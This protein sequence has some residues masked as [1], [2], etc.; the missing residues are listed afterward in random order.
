MKGLQLPHDVSIV[1]VQILV[2]ALA[3]SGVMKTPEIVHLPLKAQKGSKRGRDADN[4]EP[5]YGKWER[6]VPRQ[7]SL[8]CN[9]NRSVRTHGVRQRP[10][11]WID[12]KIMM[13]FVF[14]RKTKQTAGSLCWPLSRIYWRPGPSVSV[15]TWRWR[16][17]KNWR[18][19]SSKQATNFYNLRFE[20][21]GF[22][23][24]PFIVW[25]SYARSMLSVF[26]VFCEPCTDRSPYCTVP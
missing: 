16:T 11:N 8:N 4:A 19:S 14:V 21:W 26:H 10:V 23:T 24:S 2:T 13:V 15:R 7:V 18:S 6:H 1:F 12:R 20:P 3:V 22:I 17:E 9:W 25:R 5:K